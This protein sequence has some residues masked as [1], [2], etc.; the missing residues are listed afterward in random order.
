MVG[1]DSS[2]FQALELLIILDESGYGRLTEESCG[3]SYQPFL[4][5]LLNISRVSCSFTLCHQL[6][7]QESESFDE[8]SGLEDLLLMVPEYL[9]YRLPVIRLKSHESLTSLTVED[10]WL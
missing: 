2:W 8:L 7:F 1:T 3:L 6:L 4:Q 9:R 5:V 10:T